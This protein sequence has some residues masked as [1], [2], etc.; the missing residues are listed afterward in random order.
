MI[1]NGEFSTIKI[2]VKRKRLTK[3]YVEYVAEFGVPYLSV[4]GYNCYRLRTISEHNAHQLLVDKLPNMFPHIYNYNERKYLDINEDERPPIPEAIT[5]KPETL[6]VCNVEM[7]YLPFTPLSKVIDKLIESNDINQLKNIIHQWFEIQLLIIKEVHLLPW[8]V[9]AGNM[10]YDEQ[11]QQIHIIDYGFYESIELVDRVKK[12]VSL[13]K[14]VIYWFDPVEDMNKAY[15]D[16]NEITIDDNFRL[17]NKEVR[18]LFMFRLMWFAN[19]RNETKLHIII[20]DRLGMDKCVKL[21]EQ[22]MKELK[23]KQKHIE[24]IKKA[25]SDSDQF[26]K[27]GRS[28]RNWLG[29]PFGKVCSSHK[30]LTYMKIFPDQF[31]VC[32]DE[33]K[34]K[35]VEYGKMNRDEFWNFYVKELRM[36]K[37]GLYCQMAYTMYL[38]YD[39]YLEF[40]RMMT[41]INDNLQPI[42]KLYRGETTDR[43]NGENELSIGKTIKWENL[44]PG[45]ENKEYALTYLSNG[46]G[47]S[48]VSQNEPKHYLFIFNKIKAIHLHDYY[49]EFTTYSRRFNA[50]NVNDTN[51]LNC[52]YPSCVVI[53]NEWIIDPFKEFKVV[54]TSIIESREM[55]PPTMISNKPIKEEYTGNM[56]KVNVIELE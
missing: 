43:F 55:K 5:H 1:D 24:L 8:D 30:L 26:F 11:K 54:N 50:L 48:V 29:G 38:K 10:L 3:N 28:V 37:N 40:E 9:H 51:R 20:S 46:R 35:I 53:S 41:F 12:D 16:Y 13:T 4:I 21:H 6:V 47:T 36:K 44:I 52:F 2:D 25:I 31:K 18:E 23:F 27:I 22:V 32:Y 19:F 45:T 56:L 7:D 39:P 33:L 17:K 42:N 34:E 15:K 14:D 49:S